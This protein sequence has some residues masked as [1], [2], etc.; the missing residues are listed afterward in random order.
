MQYD[1]PKN[2]IISTAV[3]GMFETGDLQ[4]SVGL[5][6]PEAIVRFIS[7]GY[8]LTP[9]YYELDENFY[10]IIVARSPVSSEELA[11]EYTVTFLEKYIKDV[12]K[13]EVSK[14]MLPDKLVKDLKRMSDD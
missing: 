12:G 5:R 8:A 10:C 13:K 2:V 4:Y 7:N 9:L 11:L 3:D 14:C 1:L 6:V